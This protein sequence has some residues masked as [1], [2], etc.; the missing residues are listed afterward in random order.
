M[1]SSMSLKEM[2]E[3]L[4]DPRMFL[5]TY[6]VQDCDYVEDTINE[7]LPGY[8]RILSSSAVKGGSLI[9]VSMAPLIHYTIPACEYFTEI[10]FACL[11]DKSMEEL[12]KWLKNEPDT[13]DC[14][15]VIKLLCEL[16]GSSETWLEKQKMV[17]RK[18][19]NVCKYDIDR[20][21][22]LSPTVLPQADCL[23]LVHSV[24]FLAK[25]K[26]TFYDGLK[27]LSPLLKSG[28]NLIII[29][30]L[31]STFHMVGDVK[32]PHFP[33]DEEFLRNALTG[34]GYVIVDHHMYNRKT[35]C[36]YDLMDYTGVIII[37]AC[38]ER[39]I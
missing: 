2:Y 34:A 23:L 22:P 27:N 13:L 9:Q 5:Q 28:G 8:L 33:I 25:D 15:H 14:S 37:K 20:S 21:D 31:K 39:D 38:K 10:T 1:A 12:Q 32:F 24:D 6:F 16:Q 3:K 17:Q 7:L 18:I 19:I 35:Q 26:E 30:P 36:L 4:F 11:N 29:A